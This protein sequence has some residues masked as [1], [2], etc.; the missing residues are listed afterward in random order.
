MVL[1]INVLALIG[2]RLAV[3]FGI[4]RTHGPHKYQGGAITTI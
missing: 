3:G 2:M 4:Q 1:Q